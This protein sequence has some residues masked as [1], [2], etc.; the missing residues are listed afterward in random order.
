AA[1]GRAYGGG[2]GTRGGPERPWWAAT[3]S[4]SSMFGPSRCRSPPCAR[5]YSIARLRLPPA[6]R[7]EARE[8]IPKEDAGLEGKD[9]AGQRPR[10]EGQTPRDRDQQVGDPDARELRQL[11]LQILRR[12]IAHD[13]QQNAGPV[14]VGED[15]VGDEDLVA[16]GE[17]GPFSAEV[18][19]LAR[20]AEFRGERRLQRRVEEGRGRNAGG[21]AVGRREDDAERRPAPPKN[22]LGGEAPFVGLDEGGEESREVD[23]IGMGLPEDRVGSVE[24][25]PVAAVRPGL[26]PHEKAGQSR[27]LDDVLEV[28]AGFHDDPGRRVE[29]R[30]RLPEV[31]VG[32]EVLRAVV[33]R[34]V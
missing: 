30:L 10:L 2:R 14:S 24:D 27:V 13:L 20:L 7:F 21:E 25:E 28:A 33:S 11:G 32:V 17:D 31:V 15:E 3:E 29:E 4:A 26:D 16:G 19:A 1:A 9:L 6:K 12:P 18:P 8:E 22:D 23:P 34:K 5:Q